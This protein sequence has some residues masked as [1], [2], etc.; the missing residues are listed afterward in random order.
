MHYDLN[1]F[2]IWFVAGISLVIGAIQ[3]AGWRHKGL[4]VGLIVVGSV[5]ILAAFLWPLIQETW[6]WLARF[7]SSAAT[8]SSWFTVAVFIAAIILLRPSKAEKSE[9]NKPK[10]YLNTDIALEDMLRAEIKGAEGRYFNNLQDVNTSL[11]ALIQS[12]S[13]DLNGKIVAN[14]AARDV[15]FRNLEETNL[16]QI[17]RVRETVNFFADNLKEVDLD[18]KNLLYYSVRHVAVLFLED[19]ISEAP[20]QAIPLDG[21]ISRQAMEERFVEAQGFVRI[22]LSRVSK[23]ERGVRVESA[24]EF[25]ESEA[26]KIANAEAGV[27][28]PPGVTLLDKRRYLIANYQCRY[29][30]DLLIS[31]RYSAVQAMRSQREDLIGRSRLRN[32]ANSASNP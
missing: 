9:G 3:V 14:D 29:L 27:P 18:L 32:P 11:T 26:D 19:L 13:E 25:A 5:C 23:T 22:V 24:L 12:F 30:R 1:T 7:M 16:R 21:E 15:R 20:R 4:I 8:P 2:G 17:S 10:S 31:D 28:L 6:P